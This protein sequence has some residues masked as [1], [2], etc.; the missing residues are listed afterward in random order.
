VRIPLDRLLLKPNI[1]AGAS[2]LVISSLVLLYRNSGEDTEPILVR[3]AGEGLYRILD[4]RHRF[5]A[6]VI[7]GRTTVLATL[8][9]S[10]QETP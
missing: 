7:A 1:P 10:D 5:M 6:S 3:E 8:E 2:V 9:P 4:G